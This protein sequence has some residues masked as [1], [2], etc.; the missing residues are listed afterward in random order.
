MLYN[1][2][3][4]KLCRHLLVGGALF[5]AGFGMY[6]CTDTYDLDT[7]QPSNL[8]SLYGYIFDKE[9]YTQFQQLIKD[10]GQDTILSRTGSKTLFVASD[11]AFAEF[12]KKNSWNVKSYDE[13]SVTQK[14]LLLNSAMIDNPITTSML[15]TA[16]GPVKGEVCRRYSSQSLYDS[17]DVVSV[18]NPI[19]PQNNPHW[20]SVINS[21]RENVVLFRDESSAPPM[22]H[23]TAK[24][25]SSNK[26]INSDVDFLYNL[27]EGTRT[28]DDVYVGNSK[29]I[30]ANQF[31]LNGFI[32]E[33]DKVIVPL[34]N[35]AEIIRTNP[36]SSLYSSL[37]E[38]FSAPAYSADL[39][40]RY[41][42]AMGTD[43]DSVFVKRYFSKRSSGSTLTSAVVFEHD[44]QGNPAEATLKFDPGWN[45]YVSP[46]N[47]PRPDALMEEMAVMLVPTDAAITEW[48]QN[49]GGAVIRKFYESKFGDLAW[50]SI[51]NSV[52]AELLNNNMLEDFTASVPSKFA[53]SVK[54]DASEPMGITRADVDSVILGCNG[55]V[56][57]TNKVFSPSSFRS[58]LYPAVVNTETMSILNT[59]VN[60]L[61]YKHYLNV[62]LQGTKYSFFIPL[63]DGFLTYIDPVSYGQTESKLWEFHYDETKAENA[64]ITAKVYKCVIDPLTGD[65]VKEGEPDEMKAAWTRKDGVFTCPDYSNP[66]VNRMMDILDNI[67]VIG[68][69]E[70]GKYYY[71]TKGNS[72]IRIENP[73]SDPL[74]SIGNMKV[75]GTWQSD[76]NKPLNVT[77]VYQMENGNSYI[78]DGVIMGTRKSVADVLAERPECSEFFKIVQACALNAKNDKDK[79]VAAS[80]EE[81]I[82]KGNGNLLAVTPRGVPG[83]EDAT[84]AEGAKVAYLLN[85]YHYTVYAPSNDAMQK[86][87]AMGLPTVDSLERAMEYDDYCDNVLGYTEKEKPYNT[88]DSVLSVMLDFVKY[89]IQD[90]SIYVDKGFNGG[91]YESAK[92]SVT[93]S[94]QQ[95]GWV[96]GRPYTL[97]VNVTPTSM[98]VTDVS[99]ETHNVLTGTSSNGLPLHNIQA[100]EYW[101]GGTLDM[102]GN[103]GDVT[104]F[105]RA[106][107]INNTSSAVVHVIDGPLVYDKDTQF[108]YIY[109][110]FVDPN[111]AKP[112]RK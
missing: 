4:K 15:S 66:M 2:K 33:V 54:D 31:C 43:V 14:W 51:P 108:Q 82:L 81:A 16:E 40:E 13:L 26:I 10:L 59:A 69:V 65:W 5:A 6:S 104:D 32:H 55:A 23:F 11:D 60:C 39:T 89:H 100:R 44:L 86:A 107:G 73:V 12:Y 88:A 93:Y 110:K 56:Y 29:V 101:L 9:G 91:A 30:V 98:T 7:E 99:G 72:Y 64:R 53:A 18:N 76:F 22:V 85:A 8:N 28:G 97:R 17:V 80:N 35:M 67:L 78:L 47:N 109:K 41:N 111:K 63:N 19:I 90:N 83:N 105:D 50:D 45:S 20:A 95:G 52:I 38:R 77:D 112:R 42:S 37:L 102:Y 79:W 48:W 103:Q 25:L 3:R 94:E 21:G 61:D 57:L 84:A 106:E 68:A 62:K 74:T 75:Y 34:D 27:P 46:T 96:P 36:N 92:V 71:K 87:Y 49:G 1:F 70:D 58:V 24:F